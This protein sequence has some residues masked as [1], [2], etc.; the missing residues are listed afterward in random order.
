MIIEE[1]I[2]MFCPNC[3][4][5]CPDNYHFCFRCGTALPV[6]PIEE[7]NTEAAASSEEFTIAEPVSDKE[8]SISPV[9]TVEET[10][11]QSVSLPEAEE[12]PAEIVPE[13][14]DSPENVQP[15]D[16]IPQQQV[17]E[18]LVDAPAPRKGRLWP[19][20]LLIVL[21][22]V[23]GII[24]FFCFRTPEIL[25]DS[26]LPYF[27]IQE[28]ML[29]FDESLYFGSEELTVPNTVAGQ[30]VTALSDGCFSDCDDLATVIL[31]HTLTHIGSHAF[32]GCDNLTGMYIP[33]SVISIGERAFASCG[34][35]IA[36]HLDA[37]IQSIGQDAFHRCL[38]L[39]HIF[40]TGDH[41][42]WEALYSGILGAKSNIHCSDGTF[43]YAPEE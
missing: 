37:S 30:T 2:T 23:L 15:Q 38:D 8:A 32:E 22:S 9:E 18:P 12:V 20:V 41:Q 1:V 14:P 34:S 26:Q 39:E 17:S 13:T 24:V 35:H 19:P 40:F 11:E 27:Q 25:T 36:I 28:G 43:Q 29:Y 5:K 7:P 16:T 42:Q 3:G 10:P 33:N 31:P 4:T 21:M 6:I